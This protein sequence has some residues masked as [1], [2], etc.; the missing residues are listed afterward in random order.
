MNTKFKDI[1]M[2]MVKLK[3]SMVANIHIINNGII[4]CGILQ[5]GT[6]GEMCCV[7]RCP[8]ELTNVPVGDWPE[9]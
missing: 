7:L 9:N 8:A 2:K 6:S 5:I 3:W 4:M 1:K